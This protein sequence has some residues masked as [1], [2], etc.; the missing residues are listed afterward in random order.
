LPSAL[1]AD[2]LI[3]FDRSQIEAVQKTVD[4]RV[5]AK[6]DKLAAA[7]TDSRNFDRIRK[8]EKSARLVE[9]SADID[10]LWVMRKM[11]FPIRR[12]F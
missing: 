1:A 10:F 6:M 11:I 4:I 12:V 2:D 7:L 3:V 9:S 5:F 8:I